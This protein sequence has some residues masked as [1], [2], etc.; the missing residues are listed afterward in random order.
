ML[1]SDIRILGGPREHLSADVAVFQ[2]QQ[3]EFVEVSWALYRRGRPSF[4]VEY[5]D[6]PLLVAYD[7]AAVERVFGEGRRS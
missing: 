3:S 2:C 4:V 5:E 1:R 7:R 6:V